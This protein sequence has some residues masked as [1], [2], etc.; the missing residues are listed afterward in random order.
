MKILS[1]CL[2]F[3]FTDKRLS[4]V[5]K[6]LKLCWEVL[7][8]LFVQCCNQQVIVVLLILIL[9]CMYLPL[10]TPIFSHFKLASNI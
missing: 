9:Q 3:I 2:K 6:D 8:Y 1:E 10:N 5:L 7:K 4:K